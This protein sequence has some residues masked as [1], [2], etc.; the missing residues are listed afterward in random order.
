MKNAY[1]L[2]IVTILVVSDEIN[3][4]G[5]PPAEGP[6]NYAGNQFWPTFARKCPEGSLSTHQCFQEGQARSINCLPKLNLNCFVFGRAAL[7]ILKAWC[8][9]EGWACSTNFALTLAFILGGAALNV[10]N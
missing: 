4:E 2:V 8:P 1:L 10:L 9:Q 5:N 3:M 7:D 6:A